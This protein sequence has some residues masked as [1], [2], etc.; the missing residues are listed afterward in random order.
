LLAAS[1]HRRFDLPLLRKIPYGADNRYSTTRL[2]GRVHIFKSAA[3]GVAG[4]IVNLT[5]R[6]YS[7][8][9]GHL[10]MIDIITFESSAGTG[11]NGT[12]C[13]CVS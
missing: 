8:V 10:G 4:W 9:Y 2:F 5:V 11:L 13:V 12:V 1:T 3:F 7:F 6:L